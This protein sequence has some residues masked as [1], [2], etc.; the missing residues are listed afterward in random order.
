MS[1]SKTLR[2][3]GST[4]LAMPV[5]PSASLQIAFQEPFEAILQRADSALRDGFENSLFFES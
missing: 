3:K 2:A 1:E 4:F 5:T